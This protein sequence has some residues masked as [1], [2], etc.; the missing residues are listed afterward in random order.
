MRGVGCGEVVGV[1][2]VFEGLGGEIGE[3]TWMACTCT[4]EDDFGR[5]VRVPGCGIV[6][7]R[8]NCFWGGEIGGEEVEAL[9]GDVEGGR[10]DFLDCGFE[11]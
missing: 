9:F 3:E 2:F 6:H 11:F 7:H 4:A 5:G 10:L 1:H 8:L